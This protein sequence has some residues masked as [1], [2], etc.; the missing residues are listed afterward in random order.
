M[1]RRTEQERIFN[2]ILRLKNDIHTLSA[3]IQ[4]DISLMLE[5][6]KI[7]KNEIIESIKDMDKDFDKFI[8]EVNELREQSREMLQYYGYYYQDEL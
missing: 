4:N 2:D 3:Y 6:G 5:D 1:E 8:T 7:T